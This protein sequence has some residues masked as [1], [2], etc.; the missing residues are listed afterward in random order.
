MNHIAKRTIAK[1]FCSAKSIKC[2]NLEKEIDVSYNK[3]YLYDKLNNRF[4]S[5]GG[6]VTFW[7]DGVFAEIITKKDECLNCKKDKA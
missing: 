5:I 2:L 7:Q 6:I 1:H 3:T 4:T